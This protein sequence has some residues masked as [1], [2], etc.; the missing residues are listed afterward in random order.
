MEGGDP[1]VRRWVVR[2]ARNNKPATYRCPL[3]GNHLPALREHMLIA[4]EGDTARRRH[5]HTK[6]VLTARRAGRLP[7]RDE[8]GGRPNHADRRSSHAYVDVTRPTDG[9]RCRAAP[10][11]QPRATRPHLFMRDRRGGDRWSPVRAPTV[12]CNREVRVVGARSRTREGTVLSSLVRCSAGLTTGC[13]WCLAGPR[14]R[15]SPCGAS[16]VV[17]YDTRGKDG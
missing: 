10:G 16:M 3:C 6:C 7:S 5:A 2:P 12:R 13:R 8:W 1:N 14:K 9:G 17:A 15:G 11:I 4:P